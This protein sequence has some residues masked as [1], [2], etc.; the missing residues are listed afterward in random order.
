MSFLDEI[1]TEEF[2]KLLG[3]I[4]NKF[5][6]EFENGIRSAFSEMRTC[7]TQRQNDT[8][9]FNFI[10]CEQCK[11]FHFENEEHVCKALRGRSNA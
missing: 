6:R 5:E 7:I 11:R 9:I 2:D 8:G 1:I 10:Q 4:R 3:T